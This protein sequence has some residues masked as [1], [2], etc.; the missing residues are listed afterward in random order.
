MGRESIVNK[1][2]ETVKASDD[3]IVYNVLNLAKHRPDVFGATQDEVNN[4]LVKRIKKKKTVNNAENSNTH[5]KIEN[6]SNVTKKSIF[7]PIKSISSGDRSQQDIQLRAHGW[8]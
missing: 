7:E 5:L 3:E 6:R 8:N 1:I 2:K 4:V